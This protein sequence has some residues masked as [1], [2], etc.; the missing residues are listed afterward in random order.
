MQAQELPNEMGKGG[1]VGLPS[2][3]KNSR[4]W[5]ADIFVS[6]CSFFFFLRAR[7]Q[8]NGL[9]KIKTIQIELYSHLP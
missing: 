4:R 6:P 2:Q 7:Y 5:W 3:P 8:N 9:F 1:Q